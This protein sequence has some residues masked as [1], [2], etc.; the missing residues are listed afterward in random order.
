MKRKILYVLITLMLIASFGLMTAVPAAADSAN[1]TVTGPGDD[2][3]FTLAEMD[4]H[5]SAETIDASSGDTILSGQVALGNFDAGN[6][7]DVWYEVGLVSNE[8]YLGYSR[9]HNKGVYM[10]ALWTPDYYKVHMQNVPGY[11]NPPLVGNYLG[12]EDP[13]TNLWGDAGLCY[14]KVPQAA[15]QYEIV[16]HD[17]TT[18]G[19]LFDLRI[20]TDGGT[21]WSSWKY[22]QYAENDEQ[23]QYGMT[24]EEIAAY[25]YADDDDLTNARIVS[26]LF[27]ETNTTETFTAA[28]DN[29]QV[30]G[31]TAYALE[32]RVRNTN[33]G[34]SYSGIQVAIDGASSGDTID[35]AA[36][37]YAEALDLK[38]KP[39]T[40]DGAGVDATIVDAS[41]ETG[42]AVKNF[43]DSTTI[44]E[45]TLIGS[46]H[47]GFK[48]SH[49]SNIAFDSV[50]VE[51][52][53]RTAFDLN[54]V[55]TATLTDIEAVDTLNGFGLMILD[56][57]NIGVT[58]VATDGNAWGGVSIQTARASSNSIAFSGTFNVQ[59][60]V[61]LL[62]EK[63]P[64]PDTGEYH[65]I[66]GVTIPGKFGNVVYAFREGDDYQQ[67][68]Y[69]ESLDS[70][71]AF[72]Q[73]LMDSEAFTYSD[74]LIYDIAEENYYVIEGMLI[75]DA[76]AAATPGDIIN[77]AAGTY[78][79][80][81]VIGEDLTL[82]GAG[83]TTIVKPSSADVLVQHHTIPWYTG[84]KEVAGVITV[85][86]GSVTVKDLQVDGED[87]TAAPAGAHWVA[88]ILY[89]EAG[90]A[91]DNVTV[92]NMTIG[93]TGTAVRGQGIVASAVAVD[94]SVE[95]M[96]SRVSN[97][98]K[99]G[100]NALGNRLTANI[101]DNAVTG[102][103]PLPEGDEVQ[104]GILI[105]HDAAGTVNNNT[106]SNNAYIPGEWG[107]T[108]ILFCNAGG[109]A[110]GNTSTNNQMGIVAQLLDGFGGSTQT[111]SF[112]GNTVD[113]SGLEAPVITGLN[114][115]TYV[116]GSTLVITMDH[117]DLTGGAGDGISIGDLEELGAAGT[118]T[119]TI[120]NNSIANWQHGVYLISSADAGSTVSGNSF[121]NNDIQVY[122]EAG[123][124]DIAALLEA[125]N[126]D[127]AVVVNRPGDSLLPTIWSKIQ[128][129]FDTSIADDT[130]NVAA[131]TYEEGQF[132]INSDV[133]IV[134]DPAEK[135]VIRPATNLT[136]NNAAD[137]W[138]L[139]DAEVSFDLS[140]VVLDGGTLFVHQAIRNH[141]FTTI[142]NVDF[143]NIRGSES[144][145]PYRGI[146]V[147]SF[148]GTVPGGA[149]SDSHGEGGAASHLVVNGSTFEQIG[150]IGVLVKGSD[151]TADITNCD[152]TG[153]GP[154]DWLD[155]A[156]EAGGGGD[157]NVDGST[158]TACKGV[159]SVDGSTSAAILVT[160]YYGPTSHANVTD[161]ILTG[162]S[163][164]IAVGYD[165][166]DTSVVVANH[167]N[168]FGNDDFGV[169][170]TAPPV[171]AT[172][173][174]WGDESGPTHSKNAAGI[175][176]AVSENVKYRPWLPVPKDETAAGTEKKEEN[177]G[178][179]KQDFTGTNT[180]IDTTG[181][182]GTG[183]ITVT[184]TNYDP[185]EDTGG[186]SLKSGTGKQALKYVDVKIENNAYE[187]DIRITISYSDED[188]D[189]MGVNEYDL[190]LYY[191]DMDIDEWV[192]AA[193]VSVDMD[194]N[195]ISGDIPADKFTGLPIACGGDPTT[196]IENIDTHVFY[197]T[198]QEA[199]DDA[200]TG[201]TIALDD[202]TYSAFG[203]ETFPIVVD[204]AGLTIKSIDGAA[205]TIIE[206]ASSDQSAFE[207]TA[208]GV[209][210]GGDDSGFTIV[211]GGRAGIYADEVGGEGIQ[212][213]DCIFK[214]YGDGE[215]RAMFF[216][217]L[218]GDAKI[219]SNTFVA[220]RVGTAILI[221]NADG[222]AI[223]RNN[224]PP[225]TVKY[226]FVTFKAETFYPDRDPT[227]PFAE[228]VAE[229]PS[230]IDN[231]YIQNNGLN[232]MQWAIRFA[233]STKG[234]DHGEPQAQDLTIG[235]GGVQILGNRII[236]NGSGVKVDSDEVADD[237][238]EQI[239]HIIGAANIQIHSN[240]FSGND[241]AVNNGQEAAVNAQGNWWNDVAGPDVATN[242]YH[243]QTNGEWVSDHVN[244]LPWMIQFD[245]E[246]GWNIISWPI[247]GAETD[248]TSIPDVII[249][250]WYFNSETQLW[251]ANPFDAGPLDAMYIKTTAPVTIAYVISDEAT[252]PSQKEMK[253]GWN[254]VGLAELHP[255]PLDEALADVYW[256]TG[257]SELRGYSKVISPSLNGQSWACVR[258]STNPPLIPTKGYWVFMVNDGVLGGFTST[259]IE[260]EVSP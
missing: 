116:D 59:E 96:N 38:S 240:A 243:D 10:I 170:T 131:G 126:F 61:A 260:E 89:S 169:D 5:F 151:S 102:R 161:S 135:P 19:G 150:R 199:V 166:A 74:M 224:V 112:V 120:M 94:A 36:G 127:R 49:V 34:K 84:T 133:S 129:A 45:L 95:V 4:Q 227:S 8:T 203:G 253:V 167:N 40:I 146:A 83:D 130:I 181:T 46:D 47:Y 104:N 211:S 2:T 242:P 79:E 113:A 16:Y 221:R 65:D 103:G 225:G 72:A 195:T 137:A 237:D 93:D 1:L 114:A 90:G 248:E 200:L 88:G 223:T 189:R 249:A 218:W 163:G 158:V 111:V 149:G 210:I 100:I 60:D 171:D 81:V 232:E 124:L 92:V 183:D 98:D 231:V 201:Q 172:S 43:G 110:Q 247:M 229:T 69:Q 136:G 122:D 39:L 18:S 157:I 67:A 258:D 155:Y 128:D 62:L 245:L 205:A 148:G 21:T 85:E 214:S 204:V 216:E 215:S 109:S 241:G 219:D 141:G 138:F 207:V 119:A 257:E 213:L 144:G 121:E 50:K 23:V 192:E 212:V 156:F 117:N 80:Q 235:S 115:A 14:F 106:V 179:K 32:P 234:S 57:N 44:K 226:A 209:I 53:G 55:D 12:D 77:V 123:I 87:V 6:G 256:A 159:A 68:F 193:N 185:P 25:G 238:P 17:V 220:P 48:V 26:Q 153:K 22:W 252:F 9:L 118:V 188:L 186:T 78:D 35:V 63:D 41:S 217:K 73:S 51:D 91:I 206:P 99:N 105:I 142:D 101:H 42:Y 160:T 174:W 184:S 251:G 176:N 152:Y 56:S 228:Y 197:N 28:Y 24:E 162:N 187:G 75:Q 70:A 31:G 82:Q 143:R 236:G 54:T 108:G 140:N 3:I 239:A 139:V 202:G 66:T 222:A 182:T 13:Y 76:I 64:D 168:I 20:S 145:Q 173:N 11:E 259:P 37:T 33:T 86:A 254:F 177:Y 230:T 71:K 27:T 191:Y 97:Y 178:Q 244:Y 107:A 233:A 165:E 175:G 147:L 125:N 134:G 208:P 58:N 194:N 180:T 30:N 164:G 198:I 29:I 190:T 7:N 246:E 154:G 250:A 132:S 15:F 196:A 255:R 52:S